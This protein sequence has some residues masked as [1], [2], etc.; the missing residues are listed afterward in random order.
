MIGHV[1]ALHCL[2]SSNTSQ[3]QHLLLLSACYQIPTIFLQ[4]IWSGHQDQDVLPLQLLWADYNGVD[5]WFVA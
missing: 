5:A 1:I 2:P 4:F 3:C